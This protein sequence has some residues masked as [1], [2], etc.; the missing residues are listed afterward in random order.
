M[1]TLRGVVGAFDT[2]TETIVLLPCG[3]SVT[4]PRLPDPLR[5][6]SGAVMLGAVLAGVGVDAAR[7]GASTTPAEPQ[8]TANAAPERMTR[9]K[10]LMGPA[11]PSRGS[12]AAR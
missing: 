8:R 5:S 10:V 2:L 3:E 12:Q 7:T 1:V 9:G 11:Y 4:D 6:S